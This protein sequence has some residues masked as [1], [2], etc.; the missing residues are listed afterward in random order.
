MILNNNAW[1]TFTYS[2]VYVYNSKAQTRLAGELGG[3]LW[4]H[5]KKSD[6]SMEM[7]Q[8]YV[9]KFFMDEGMKA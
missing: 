7:E 5:S 2:L 4:L 3:I 8:G 6:K 1:K 9:I